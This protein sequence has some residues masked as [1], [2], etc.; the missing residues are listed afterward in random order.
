MNFW[1]FLELFDCLVAMMGFVAVNKSDYCYSNRMWTVAVM[2]VTFYWN[3]SLNSFAAD[4]GL[5]AENPP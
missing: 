4:F 3:L 1:H 5:A 2:T